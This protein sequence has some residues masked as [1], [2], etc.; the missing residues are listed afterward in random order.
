MSESLMKARS[1][2]VLL[3]VALLVAACGESFEDRLAANPLS[4]PT[5]SFAEP[6]RQT[7][8]PGSGS[9]IIGAGT[10]EQHTTTFELEPGFAEQAFE[11]LSA[12][13]ED[14]GYEL[15]MVSSPERLPSGNWTGTATGLHILTIL[16]SDRTDGTTRVQVT[17]R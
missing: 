17:L 10:G 11:E 9:T 14:A 8:S 1:I 3:V 16:V 12:Q 4:N 7:S 15:R 13:A 6:V 5:L 2:A